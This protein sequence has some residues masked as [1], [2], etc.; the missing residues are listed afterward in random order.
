MKTISQVVEIIVKERPFLVELLT[1]GLVN[2]SSLARHLK[3]DV[4]KELQKEVQVGAI[5]MSLKR[6]VPSL[7][8]K[9]KQHVKNILSSVDDI[10][11]RSKLSDYS[12][13]NSDSLMKSQIEL[14]NCIGTDNEIFYTIVQG[15]YEINI[16][17]SSVYDSKVKAIFENE[18]LVTQKDKLS[19]IT[20]K[21]P[22][23]NIKQPGLYY[24]IL[25]ELAWE[26]INIVE[27][28]STSNEFTIVVE[29]D[30]IEKAFLLLKRM[31]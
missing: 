4:E 31:K 22:Q 23:G 26:G 25:K 24:F 9:H 30:D 11:L 13:K 20:L 12:F 18:N 19:S 21:L 14:M 5:V 3:E 29:D 15:V 10:I 2:L 27:V 8:M 16:V 7:E 6:L 1:E 17:I 28:I